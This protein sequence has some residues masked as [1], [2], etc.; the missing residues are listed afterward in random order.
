M[1]SDENGVGYSDK[2]VSSAAR[3]TKTRV[4][5]NLRKKKRPLPHSSGRAVPHPPLIGPIVRVGNLG[6]FDALIFDCWS[7]NV[8]TCPWRCHGSLISLYSAITKLS[9]AYISLKF[10]L[11]NLF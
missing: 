2:I 7:S 11:Y 9:S 3:S 1:F 8:R 6:L 4:A 10:G 5:R